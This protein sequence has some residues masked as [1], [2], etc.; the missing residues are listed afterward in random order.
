[1]R[2]QLSRDPPV[3]YSTALTMLRILNKKGYVTYRKD[4]RAFIYSAVV[5][6]RAARKDALRH[7][8]GRFFGDSPTALA[9][10]L[11]D[12]GEID[13]AELERLRRRV[14]SDTQDDR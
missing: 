10:N 9:Q 4:G 2:D 6:R 8:L 1:M 3:A 5:D 12:E 13:L 7:L 14:E 11:I